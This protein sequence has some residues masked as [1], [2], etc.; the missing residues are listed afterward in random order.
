MRFRTGLLAGVAATAMGAPSMAQAQGPAM[1]EELVVTAQRREQNIQDVA[2][3]LAVLRPEE[4]EERG[5]TNMNEYVAGLPSVSFQGASTAGRNKVVIRGISADGETREERTTGLYFGEAPISSLG[6]R[7]FSDPK[8]VDIER[9]EVLRGPQG[10]LFGAGAMGGALRVMPAAPNL[11]AIQAHLTQ[12]VSTTRHGEE[13]YETSGAVSIPLVQDKLAL[14]VVAYN[15]DTGGFVDNAYPGSPLFGAPAR[16]EKN[17]ND[18]N[19]T[20][21]RIALRFEPSS[22]L[23]ATL[24]YLTQESQTGGLSDI[25]PT[26]AGPFGQVR[27]GQERIL[28]DFEMLNLTATYDFGGVELVIATTEARKQDA[29]VFDIR[30]FLAPFG[31]PPISLANRTETDFFAQEIRL[32]SSQPESP[33]FWVLGGY[34]SD[35]ELNPIR[36]AEWYGSA[37][38]LATFGGIVNTFLGF[39]VADADDIYTYDA[40]FREKQKA[41]FVDAT[42]TFDSGLSIAAGLRWASYDYAREETQAGVFAGGFQSPAPD[43]VSEDVWLP[44]LNVSYKASE[45][46]LYYAQAAKGFRVGRAN[47]RMPNSCIPDL[48]EFGLTPDTVPGRAKSDSLW[49]YEGGVKYASEDGRLTANFAAYYIDW[50]DIQVQFLGSACGFEFFSNA[51]SA[52]NRG[53]EL[54]LTG[55]PVDGLTLGLATSYNDIRLD[56]DAPL[57]SGS[58]GREGDRLPGT[59]RWTLNLSARYGWDIG[60]AE[61]FVRGNYI[62]V[63]HIYS[64]FERDVRSGDY[65][66]LNLSAGIDYD[67]FGVQLFADNV[68]DVRAMPKNLTG[69]VGSF[70][71][72]PRFNIARPRTVGL[73]LMARY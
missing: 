40:E 56:E 44:R 5:I 28:D 23:S 58:N 6:E 52:T 9:V 36:R 24:T 45:S 54:E 31:L 7:G 14:R 16:S 4:V 17:A 2:G 32:V 66:L 13:S 61:A 41:L 64:S 70:P 26:L 15:Y 43:K 19:T 53:A 38:G 51:N 21:G 72:G 12:S 11:N 69:D 34:Y 46:T 57:A 35:K 73:R 22:K 59:P 29:E 60:D 10:T 71:L 50:Q 65:G 49:S 42:Y 33:L 25:Q 18:E 47:L 67:R 8:L 62:Y 37:T 55:Q 3:S 1:I 63:S 48:A 39:P 20:G 30:E 68:A 27:G